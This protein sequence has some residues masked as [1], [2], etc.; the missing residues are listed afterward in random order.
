MLIRGV[1]LFIVKLEINLNE[2]TLTR[3]TVLKTLTYSN[4]KETQV[5][6][7]A[8]VRFN[9]TSLSDVFFSHRNLNIWGV[10]GRTQTKTKPV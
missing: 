5:F 4:L 9:L 7:E 3:K 1:F 2:E 10:G 8:W 6:F